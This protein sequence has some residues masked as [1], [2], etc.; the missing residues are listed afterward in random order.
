MYTGTP[1]VTV[2]IHNVRST[3]ALHVNVVDGL[4]PTGLIID[5]ALKLP[6]F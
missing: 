2:Q 1:G 4:T 6:I 3:K 5:T